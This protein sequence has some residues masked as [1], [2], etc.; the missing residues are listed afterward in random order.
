VSAPHHVALVPGFFGFSSL[1]DFTYFGHV[2]DLL[3]EIGPPLGLGGEVL[4]V[5]TEPTASLPRRA[6]LL[7]EAIAGLLDRSPGHVSLVGHSSGGLDARLFVTPGAALPTGAEVERC[8]RAVRSVVTVSTPHRGTPLSSAFVG[9]LGQQALRLLSLATMHALR[10]G[11]LP[12]SVVLKMARLLRLGRAPP[13]GVLEQLSQQLLGDHSGEV[14]RAMERYLADVRSDQGLISQLAPGAMEL[15]NSSAMDRPGLPYGSVVTQA[16]PPSLRSLV[17]A[18]FDPYAQATHALFV[19]LW[20]LAGR[21]PD[22]PLPRLDEA[23][24]GVLRRA[25]GR[26]PTPKA[27]D[28]IVPT[29]SQ[30]HGAVLHAAWADHHDVL[31]HFHGPNHVPPHFDWLASGSGFDRTGFE[32]LWKDVAR[33]LAHPSAAHRPRVVR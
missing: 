14:R 17:T 13:S 15:F 19:A 4:V 32:G 23:S 33:F 30:V 11:R 12:L 21:A 24:A 1:S 28:G 16:R 10:S 8:A 20:R 2:R 18:G 5:A 25:Y 27:N 6:A 9:L 29:R 26:I 3:A 7:C 31:G 22:A